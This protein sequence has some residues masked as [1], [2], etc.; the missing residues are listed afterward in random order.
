MR[1]H[2]RLGDGKRSGIF[3][4]VPLQEFVIFEPIN[5]CWLL[6]YEVLH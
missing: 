1:R 4:L 3:F 6:A 2:F 5:S